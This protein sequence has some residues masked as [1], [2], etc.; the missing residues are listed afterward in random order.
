MYLE[1]RAESCF[2]STFV[3]KRDARAI[4]KLVGRWFTEGLGASPTKFP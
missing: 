3:L 4:G 1:A 2:S